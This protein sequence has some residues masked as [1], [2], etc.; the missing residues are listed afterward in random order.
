MPIAFSYFPSNNYIVMNAKITAAR[1]R[2]VNYKHDKH[3]KQNDRRGMV[4]RSGLFYNINI[5]NQGEAY[6]KAVVCEGNR[7]VI[8]SKREEDGDTIYSSHLT[9]DASSP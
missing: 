8:P 2:P 1:A 4:N 7:M 5:E 6:G 3:I 9:G